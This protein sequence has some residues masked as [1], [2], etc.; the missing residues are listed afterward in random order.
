[1]NW[2]CFH[3]LVWAATKRVICEPNWPFRI[4]VCFLCTVNLVQKKYKY[5]TITWKLWCG[6]YSWNKEYYLSF[7]L[8]FK[9]DFPLIS[10]WQCEGTKWSHA[11]LRMTLHGPLAYANKCLRAA[12]ANFSETTTVVW[13]FSKCAQKWLWLVSH[14]LSFI[15]III[16]LLL[17]VNIKYWCS[18]LFGVLF[19]ICVFYRARWIEAVPL[20]KSQK[21]RLH[22]LIVK[23][24][25]VFRAWRARLGL[26][27][28]PVNGETDSVPGVINEASLLALQKVQLGRRP[29]QGIRPGGL[30]RL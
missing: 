1:M 3:R 9:V 27:L 28:L 18:L 22:Q 16:R 8:H 26:F 6:T 20:V 2:S 15:L 30:C 21:S 25:G 10:L 11:L 29:W 13:E 24:A 5:I 12:G 19:I 7:R 14:R 4:L 17:K 23:S